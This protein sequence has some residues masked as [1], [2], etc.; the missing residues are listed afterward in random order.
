MCVIYFAFCQGF[1]KDLTQTTSRNVEFFRC[2]FSPLNIQFNEIEKIKLDMY[3][4][5]RAATE[6]TLCTSS[7]LDSKLRAIDALDN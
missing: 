6:Q 7:H 5:E 2:I 3:D 4:N 1:S